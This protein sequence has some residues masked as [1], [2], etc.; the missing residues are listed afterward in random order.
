MTDTQPERTLKRPDDSLHDVG[1][2]TEELGRAV[3]QRELLEHWGLVP[4][5]RVLEVGCGVGRLP[6]E[7]STYFEGGGYVGFDISEDAV[8]WLNTH[9]APHLPHFRF[10][11]FHVRNARYR[12]TIGQRAD[13]ITFPWDDDSF[14]MACSFA[15][16][17]HM[18]QAEIANYLREIGRVL[19]P[20]GRAVLTLMAITEADHELPVLKNRSYSP[21]GNGVYAQRPDQPT[22]GLAFRREL[23]E[24]MAIESGLSVVAYTEGSW[25]GR[26]P[27]D[28]AVPYVGGDV[29]VF[30]P[31]EARRS[32]L[33]E[34]LRSRR[35]PVR[36]SSPVLSET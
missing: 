32:P 16:F 28:P 4:T 23:I 35:R 2:D 14:D 24:A 6:Y 11:L 33:L 13:R 27:V 26:E 18:Q 31:A 7:L 29:F 8:R 19:R 20:G 15:V 9:Y 36:I 17:M 12:P 30:Q 22:F 5:S 25:H 1:P 3:R 10:H 34:R 21:I